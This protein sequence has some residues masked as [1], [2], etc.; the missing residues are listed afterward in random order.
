[1]TV[2]CPRCHTQYRV[3]DA[4][5]RQGRPVFKCTRCNSVFSRETR[6]SGGRGEASE[7]NL[8]FSFQAPNEDGSEAALANCL[9]ISRPRPR[10]A[11]V[12]KMF[13]L[14]MVLSSNAV[15]L[16]KYPYDVQYF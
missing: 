4:R 5:I 6:A 13:R 1:M 16:T 9:T 8:S 3:P 11:P 10:L 7:K 2:E 12:I 14:N 15:K